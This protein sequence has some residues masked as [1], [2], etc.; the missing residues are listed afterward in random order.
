MAHAV[1]QAGMVKFLF[2]QQA[3]QVG[4]D[5]LLVLPILDIG[6]HILKHPHNLDIC[7]AVARPF[8]GT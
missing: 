2:M 6:F 4:A 3:Q 7:A 8:Q 5:F 1:N